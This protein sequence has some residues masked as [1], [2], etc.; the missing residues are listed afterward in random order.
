MSS[1]WGPPQLPVQLL[2]TQLIN[3]E[4]T[5]DTPL[6]QLSAPIGEGDAIGQLVIKNPSNTNL[7]FRIATSTADGNAWLEANPTFPDS[8]S[9]DKPTLVSVRANARNLAPG[10][11]SG[12][13][14]LS[15]QQ[16]GLTSQLVSVPVV[17]AV[18]GQPMDLAVSQSALSFSARTNTTQTLDLS[19]V[20]IGSGS[21]P[22]TA[23]VTQGAGFLRLNKSGETAIGG[24]AA[25][26]IDIQFVTNG[27]AAGEYHGEIQVQAQG[28]ARPIVVSV[29]GRVTSGS[30]DSIP[31]PSSL[32]FVPKPGGANPDP[33]GIFLLNVT[34]NVLFNMLASPDNPSAGVG[35]LKVEPRPGAPGQYQAV[36]S[37]DGLVPGT[38]RATVNFSFVGNATAQLQV[39]AVK[40]GAPSA[41]SSASKFRTAAGCTP[42]KFFPLFSSAQPR[43][44]LL[45]GQPLQTEIVVVDD[46]GELA[47]NAAASSYFNN[48]EP[49]L[50]LVPI[51]DGRW[52]GTWVPKINESG[53]VVL[54]T[55]TTNVSRSVEP[56]KVTVRAF[57]AGN[58]LGP[59]LAAKGAV[60][61]I[62]GTPA[63]AI[64]PG[65]RIEV[66]GVRMA[67]QGAATVS[68]G[69]VNL[70]V[71]TATPEK[72]T[73]VVPANFDGRGRQSLVVRTAGRQSAPFM[74][75]VADLWPVVASVYAAD[76]SRLQLNV[77]GI[78]E[79]AASQDLSALV[80][81]ADDRV[82]HALAI[83]PLEPGLWRLDLADCS[84]VD[85]QPSSITAGTRQAHSQDLTPTRRRK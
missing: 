53:E 19:M 78:A 42:T 25:Q 76:G 79:A 64:A 4:L 38:Y 23:R 65:S 5:V 50:A 44:N 48:G 34:G 11:Y 60:L 84:V 37:F 36:V 56:A 31:T 7:S 27:L 26:L 57:L 28:A 61:S 54:D 80:I 46:C 81:A 73:V 49:S 16:G 6:V 47:T 9:L 12:T 15:A 75:V 83:A 82:C 52:S 18:L 71:L 10:T 32:A 70:E 8:V 51:G 1:Q 2:V 13:I 39:L 85:G 14:E 55:L 74:I 68:L 20:A 17:F 33:R 24:G 67:V 3:P 45:V 43:F 58:T 30:P 62:D 41:S 29:L 72:I 69:G 59:V 66:R 22:W 35:W 77:S 21:L 40:P 63:Q